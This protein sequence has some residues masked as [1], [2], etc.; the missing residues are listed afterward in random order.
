MRVKPWGGR[1]IASEKEERK[2]QRNPGC[3]NKDFIVY[4]EKFSRLASAAQFHRERP[5]QRRKRSATEH[6]PASEL[7]PRNRTSSSPGRAGPYPLRPGPARNPCCNQGRHRS[8]VRA[9]QGQQST[10]CGP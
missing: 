1:V 2:M 9:R 4:G 5:Q 6:C 8:E 7:R 10:S 3:L